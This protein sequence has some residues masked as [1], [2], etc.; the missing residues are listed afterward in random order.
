MLR[1]LKDFSQFFAHPNLLTVYNQLQRRLVRRGQRRHPML[2]PV[3]EDPSNQA[4]LAKLQEFATSTSMQLAV[5]MQQHFAKPGKW[6]CFIW[7][8]PGYGHLDLATLHSVWEVY[9]DPNWARK[10]L[11][12]YGAQD[13][14]LEQFFKKLEE[15]MAE[16]SMQRHGRAKQLVVFFGAAGIGTEGGWGADAVLHACCKVV[17]RPR[18]TDQR[19]GRVM[20]VDEHH[21]TG[22]SSAVNGKQPCEEELDHE[23]PTRRADWKPPAGQ[24][25][26]R[27]LRP[28]LEPAAGGSPRKPPQAPRSSQAATTAAASE[29]GLITPPP[30]KRS[31]RTE[32]EQ[33]AEPSQPTKGKGKAQGKAAKAKPAPQP[34]RWLDRDC[35]AAL[36]MQRIGESRW[37]PLQLCWW[38]E[39][40]ALP[41]KGKEYPELATNEHER[42]AGAPLRDSGKP[43]DRVPGK[44]VTVDEFRTSRVSSILNSPQPCEEELDSSKPTRPKGWKHKPGQVQDRLLRSA[45][46]KR[47]EAPVRG[48]MWCPWLAQ[49]TPGDLG[50]WVDRDCNAALNLQRAGESKL[51]PLELCRWPHRGRLPAQ[52]KEY[53]ALGCKKLR[54]RAPKAQAQQPS[55]NDISDAIRHLTLGDLREQCR[56]RGLNPGDEDAHFSANNYQR[57]GGNQNLGNRLTNRPSSR[58]MA[59]PG[60]VSQI[61]FGERPDLDAR[62]PA[63]TRAAEDLLAKM[64]LGD[65]D[66]MLGNQYGG[67]DTPAAGARNA[68]MQGHLGRGMLSQD[69]VAQ[70]DAT[71]KAMT[72]AELRT[73]CRNRGVSPAGSL[74]A[75]RERLGDGSV[76]EAMHGN[77]GSGN[78]Y[79]RPG[80]QQNVGNFLADRPSSRVL[81]P[82]GGNTQISFGDH[83]LP[84]YGSPAPKA[85]PSAPTQAAPAPY[86]VSSGNTPSRDPG[87]VAGHSSQDMNVGHMANNYSRPNGQQNVGNYITGRNSSRVLAPPG[88][89]SQITFG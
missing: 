5:S 48:L 8:V 30:A 88:G 49:A 27:L 25:D 24:V 56:A 6:W 63:V 39:Q 69:M 73:E 67:Y 77:P 20:L 15:D 10:R 58:V 84:G 54:D 61:Q 71:I 50:K 7:H 36:N 68:P 19:R 64:G 21:T 75:L 4:L 35:N 51:R 18:G 62:Q 32:A 33:A 66:Q 59:P 26:L 72:M 80:G 38:P 79:A 74:V 85:A 45:W 29:P 70:T 23:Q 76:N 9:L 2:M 11:R 37:R 83:T 89:K 86:G 78:N 43:T 1:Q 52:G 22:V 14:A 65:T 60:G 47:F 13:R 46:S 87:Y 82:P 12:L 31:K 57:P 55:A 28:S 40:G 53:P 3:F 16:V 34:G 42:A 81:A 17:C 41:A 44:V